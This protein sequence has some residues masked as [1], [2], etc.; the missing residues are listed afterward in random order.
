[1]SSSSRG[2]SGLT[3][4]VSPCT[5]DLQIP[6]LPPF[7]PFPLRAAC[8][9]PL[10]GFPIRLTAILKVILSSTS[11]TLVGILFAP[12]RRTDPLDNWPARLKA[13]IIYATETLLEHLRSHDR[14][15]YRQHDST[16]EPFHRGAKLGEVT[17]GGPAD[18]CTV[19]HGMIRNDV[20]TDSRVNGDGHIV[21]KCRG[22]NRSP[23]PVMAQFVG[24]GH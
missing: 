12:T 22:Q 9:F 8:C 4:P 2:N 1:M 17:L 21:A 10:L 5:Q 11:P 24:A 14:R 6:S 13:E 19:E 23:F 16:V 3:V 15:A 7:G 20:V 18:C